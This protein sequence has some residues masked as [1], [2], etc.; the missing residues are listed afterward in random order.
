MP[1]RLDGTID[2]GSLEAMMADDTDIVS[3][4]AANSETGVVHPVAE[5]AEIVHRHDALLHCDATQAVGKIP[6]DGGE[7][8][9]DMVT[10]S[11]HKIY[12]PKGCGALVATREARR[13]ISP[14]IYGGGQ[15]RDM[16]SGTLNVPA[17]AGF[18]EA[19]R[20]AITDG[21][22]DTPRQRRLRDE[23]ERRLLKDV[24][25]ISVNGHPADRLPNTSNVRIRGALA[26][27]V[28][29]R[30]PSVRNI[31][32]QRLLVQ[33]DGALTCIGGDGP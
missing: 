23:F 19:C 31:H 21:L 14:I 28:M 25:D 8:G 18:G 3:V 1:V 7:L 29:A 13:R 27:A 33:H 9:A 5:V 16:R 17:I 11:S 4:M 32:G 20:I 30:M 22:A 12:G 24:P 10:L 2:M 6:F 26:D 15:E